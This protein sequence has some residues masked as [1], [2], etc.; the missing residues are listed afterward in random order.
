[1]K[2]SF[3]NAVSGAQSQQIRMDTVAN[4]IANLNTTAFKGQQTV[5]SQLVYQNIR[6]PEDEQTDL[7]VGSGSKVFA[8]N[9]DFRTTTLSMTDNQTDFA[10][11]GRGFFAVQNPATE[12][13]RYTRDGAFMLSQMEDGEFYLATPNKWLVMSYEGEPITLENANI[14]TIGVFDFQNLEYMTREGDNTF[15]A[16]EFGGEPTAVYGLTQQGMLELSNVDMP[17]EFARLIETQR[18]FQLSV[19]MMTTSDEVIQTINNLK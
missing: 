17:N 9:N 15:T 18:A 1:M 5:F 6:R 7:Q 14:E 16:G 12:E 11:N 3:Y 13:I 19:R 4:N 8:T 10:I 2:I